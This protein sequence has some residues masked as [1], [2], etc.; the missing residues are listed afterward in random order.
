LPGVFYL[1]KK[2]T[3]RQIIKKELGDV[4]SSFVRTVRGVN[5][6]VLGDKNGITYTPHFYNTFSKTKLQAF[7]SKIKAYFIN[8]NF[9]LPLFFKKPASNAFGIAIIYP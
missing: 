5:R 9:I 3:L 7:F 2:F 6:K 1:Q 4:P 8:N